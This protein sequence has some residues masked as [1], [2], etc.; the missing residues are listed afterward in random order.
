MTNKAAVVRLAAVCLSALVAA[1]AAVAQQDEGDQQTRLPQ[2]GGEF[3]TF[4]IYQ[5]DS[6]FDDT[7][8]LYG[9]YGQSV[10]YISTMIRPSIEWTPH[11]A[12]TLFYEIEIG[13]N[14]WSRNDAN[15]GDA[16]GEG[17]PVFR[18]KQFW[19]AVRFPNTSLALTA[20]YQYVHDPTHLALDRYLGAAVLSLGWSSGEAE[21]GVAQIPDTTYEGRDPNQVPFDPDADG[22]DPNRNNF[23]NDDFVAYISASQ[24]LTDS[25]EIKPGVFYRRDGTVVGRLRWY[26]SPVVSFAW[27]A[28]EA[29][30]LELD[31]AGQAGMFEHGGIDNRDVDLL[32]GAAQFRVELARGRFSVDAGALVITPDEDPHDL[33]DN[34][35]D[36]SGFSK[37]RCVVLSQNWLQDTY[38]NLDERAAAQKAGLLLT[39]IELDAGIAGGLALFAI[40]GYGMVL[41]DSHLSDGP[42]LGTE[43]D[44]G[45]RAD[46]YGGRVRLTLMGGAVL[47]GKAAAAL[48]NEIDTEATQTLWNVQSAFEIFF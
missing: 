10:G 47:P 46:M 42:E 22:F 36:Y 12:I 40:A 27:R 2:I 39:D 20:G 11:E 45:I 7:E 16:T 24:A 3:R 18:H 9:E 32:G 41:E 38:N 26:F 37:S 34:S 30:R 25:M 31:I 6:D 43:A 15:Q 1:S 48:S 4:F 8:P 23:N 33:T 29:L 21:F 19:G 44:A 5:N 35:F 14:I 13:D 28:S 17:R